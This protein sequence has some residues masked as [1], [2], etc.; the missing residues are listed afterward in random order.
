MALSYEYSIG[1][2]R[3]KEKSLL[4]RQDI[5]QLLGCKSS[6]ELCSMLGDKGYG[7]GK[8]VDE[9]IENRDSETRS[10]IK[11]VA[12]DM[13]VFNPFYLL[14]DAHNFK[15]ALKGTMA[16][17]EYRGLMLEPCTVAFDTVI[18]AVEGRRMNLLPEFMQK[19]CDE[20]YEIIAHTGDA[21]EGDAL[22]DRAFMEEI[23]RLA[24]NSGSEFLYNY[25]NT[26]VF[27][28]NVKI[29]IRSAR[30]GADRAYLE[31]ALCETAD[32]DK[33]KIIEA[34]QKGG[35]ALIETLSKISA[36]GCDKAIEQFK[37]SPSAF[38]RFVDDRLILAARESCKRTSEGAEPLIGY[39][40]AREAEKKVIHIIDSGIRTNTDSEI[41]R[42]RLREI[43]G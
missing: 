5:E 16:D 21:R 33:N 29:A 31:K 2:V 7:E 43:Y 41:I 26:F 37:K 9:A 14:N 34:A 38:E 42:E 24:Q 23:L 6:A 1:S 3:A 39:Y 20:A 15:V 32:F 12:P 22:V 11:S 25:F 40:L 17:R 10:Y 19:P 36:C 8:T 28:S 4:N 35:D 18:K 13:S 27:Y 30:S